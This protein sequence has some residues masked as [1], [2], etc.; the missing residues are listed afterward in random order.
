MLLQKLSEATFGSPRADQIGLLPDAISASFL[1]D[2]LRR[3]LSTI[4]KQPAVRQ[5]AQSFPMTIL[6]PVSAMR[7]TSAMCCPSRATHPPVKAFAPLRGQKDAENQRCMSAQILP[8][9]LLVQIFSD[10]DQGAFAVCNRLYTAL[11]GSAVIYD[12]AGAVPDA[13]FD[14]MDAAIVTA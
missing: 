9:S 8:Y 14:T 4:K 12:P 10:Y 6:V 11:V 2:K 3:S 13:A 7:S 5:A 1:V